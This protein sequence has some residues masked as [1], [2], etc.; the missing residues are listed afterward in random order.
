MAPPNFLIRRNLSNSQTKELTQCWFQKKIGDDS[1]G[2]FY[3]LAYRI[4]SAFFFLLFDSQII[5]IDLM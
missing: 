2:K 1:N 5:F 4:A 3:G